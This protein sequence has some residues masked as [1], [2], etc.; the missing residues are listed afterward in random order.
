MKATIIRGKTKRFDKIGRRLS[1]RVLDAHKR[2]FNKSV[3]FI[4]RRLDQKVS[5][6]NFTQEQL[7]AKGNPYARKHG[8][9]Q[10]GKIRPLRPYMVHER[11]GGFRRAFKVL[12]TG[13]NQYVRL[14]KIEFEPS[15]AYQR[16]VFEGTR[17]L[18]GRNPIAGTLSEIRV[19]K[20]LEMISRISSDE[21]DISKVGF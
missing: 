16:Y 17:I 14:F 13:T 9:I 18:F 5:R 20:Q 7:D 6:T 10:T 2:R 3:E 12:K 11:T 15:A 8:E 4:E 21:L 1:R 19:Q